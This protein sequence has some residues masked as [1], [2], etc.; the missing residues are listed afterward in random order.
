LL[1]EEVIPHLID[2]SVNELL[3][4]MP[5]KME[6]KH[7]VFDLNKEGAPGLDGFGDF[8]LSDLLGHCAK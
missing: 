3:T 7:A 6:I 5:S 4:K 2:E 1:V 8:F